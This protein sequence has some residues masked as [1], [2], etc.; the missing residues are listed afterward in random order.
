VADYNRQMGYVE[1]GDRMTDSYSVNR[2]TLKWSKKHFFR[3]F[4]LAF[5]NSYILVSSLGGKKI[6]HSDFRNTLLGN[7]LV[8]AGQEW[9]LQRPV[10]RPL[11]AATQVI[12]FEEHG[13][14]HW[15]IPSATRRRCVCGQGCHQK[16]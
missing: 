3:L 6:S 9:N 12:R 7:L 15:A 10:G 11:A 14:K 5:L 1:T 2:H 16:C 8:Q 4:D 13:R